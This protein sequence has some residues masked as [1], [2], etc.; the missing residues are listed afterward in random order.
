MRV[1]VFYKPVSEHARKVEEFM[2]EYNRRTGRALETIDPDSRDGSYSAEVHDIV[3]YPTIL[4][5][6][7][8][9]REL[10][11]WRGMLPTISEVSFYDT[12]V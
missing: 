8:D 1:L 2:H 4:A 12:T 5:L 10:C 11:R 7:S 3:E 6:D 9:G